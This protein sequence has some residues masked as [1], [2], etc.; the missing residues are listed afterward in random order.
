MFLNVQ[1]QMEGIINQ[2]DIIRD[3]LQKKQIGVIGGIYSLSSGHVEFD[4]QNAI[5]S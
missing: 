5:F 3:L 2:S 1:K 4:H